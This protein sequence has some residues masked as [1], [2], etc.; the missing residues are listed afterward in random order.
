MEG[1]YTLSRGFLIAGAR[2]V[3]ASQWSVEDASTAELMGDFFQRI[4]SA[5]KA[6]RPIDYAEALRDAKR[7]IRNQERWAAPFYWAPF[8]LMGKK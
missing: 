8:I 3:I 4:A 6:A 7:R 2:R 5:E 1:I